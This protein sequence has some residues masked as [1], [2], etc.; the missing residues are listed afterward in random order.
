MPVVAGGGWSLRLSKMG[1]Q[2]LILLDIAH[3]CLQGAKNI[4]QKNGISK[5]QSLLQA[6]LEHLECLKKNTFDFIFCERDPLEYCIHK[7]GHAFGHLIRTLKP[8]GVITVS[9]GNRYR[10]EQNLVEKKKYDELL[11]FRKN[12]ILD[13]TEGKIKPFTVDSL[14][15]LFKKNNLKLLELSGRL[16]IA[17][18][19][20]GQDHDELY[21][22]ENKQYKDRLIELELDNQDNEFYAS[23][24]SHI[25]AAGQKSSAK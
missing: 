15:A 12:G 8:G 16:T 24:S 20:S 25:F 6:D 14:K 2:N 1:Y 9:V 3:S 13:T 7:Q 21:H 19:L 11:Q 5:N 22:G 18:R 4:Y 10:Y 23:A 17:D